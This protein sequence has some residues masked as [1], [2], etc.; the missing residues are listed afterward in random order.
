MTNGL[1]IKKKK[2]RFALQLQHIQNAA[3]QVV[4][5]TR[6]A[7]HTGPVLRA[8]R[9]LPA[10]QRTGCKMLLFVLQ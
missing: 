7:D 10:H 3:A 2:N 6:K 5:K 1:S 8:S 9:W 4:T